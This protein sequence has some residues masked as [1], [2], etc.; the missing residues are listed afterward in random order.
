MLADDPETFASATVSLLQ[1]APL[2]QRLGERGR[3]LVLDRTTG[4]PSY[5]RL[6]ETFQEAVRK[7]K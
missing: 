6:E 4:A 5:E 3:Q 2:R 1:D 7:R